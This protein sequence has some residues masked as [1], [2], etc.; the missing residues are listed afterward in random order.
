[1]TK[2]TMTMMIRRWGVEAKIK[3]I[4]ERKQT[5]SFNLIAN[6]NMVIILL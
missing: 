2:K 3:I 4:L 1:M 5:N 6:K